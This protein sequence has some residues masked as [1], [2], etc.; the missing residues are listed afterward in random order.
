MPIEGAEDLGMGEVSIPSPASRLRGLGFG[1]GGVLSSPSGIRS[2]APAV[3]VFVHI[4]KN[5]SGAPTETLK[6]P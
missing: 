4:V 6:L 1:V 3:N 2:R 5:A